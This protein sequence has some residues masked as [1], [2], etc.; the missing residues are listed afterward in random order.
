MSQVQHDTDSKNVLVALGSNATSKFGDAHQT[1]RG[2]LDRLLAHFPDLVVSRHYK[3]P[4]FPEGSGPEFVNAACGFYSD[5]NPDAI[6]ELLHGV[7]AE[8]GRKRTR[9]W[10]QRTLDLD[11]IACGQAVRPDLDSFLHW[12]NLAPE[13]QQADA[14]DRLILPHPRLQDRPFVLVPLADIAPNWRHPVTGQT[15]VQM[16]DAHPAS[17]LR[18]VQPLK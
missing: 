4:A 6:L 17:A 8:F 2:A 18:D 9:R 12:V 15:V 1:L 11:L 5:M 13:A 16:R 7:E 10:G 3:T 14:P